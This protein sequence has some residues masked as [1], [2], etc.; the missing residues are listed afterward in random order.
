MKNNSEGLSEKTGQNLDEKSDV[1]G[2]A[3]HLKKEENV[4]DFKSIVNSYPHPYVSMY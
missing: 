3:R 4:L 1:T 2:N